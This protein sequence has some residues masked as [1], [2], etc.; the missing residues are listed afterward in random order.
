MNPVVIDAFR[1]TIEPTPVS[2]RIE[3]KSLN[4][5]HL[6]DNERRCN[7]CGT[8]KRLSTDHKVPQ[9]LVKNLHLLELEVDVEF[10]W[11]ENIS[12]LCTEHN[13]VK[14]GYIQWGDEFVGAF[15]KSLADHINQKLKYAKKTRRKNTRR[16]GTLPK[17]RD[18]VRVYKLS[19]NPQ[20]SP[21]RL[22]P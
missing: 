17:M 3:R 18:E 8:T 5:K 2:V 10:L 15:M 9:W 12:T 22:V 11:V 7:V 4:V 14:G 20:K 16:V 6:A 21:Q 1:T 19:R 13:G